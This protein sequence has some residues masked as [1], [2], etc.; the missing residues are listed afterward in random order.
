MSRILPSEHLQDRRRPFE[1][2]TAGEYLFMIT[3]DLSGDGS[4]DFLILIQRFK[5][6]LLPLAS[7][8]GLT[9]G[10]HLQLLTTMTLCT[11]Y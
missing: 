8:A 6:L 9:P 1:F 2:R 7:G 3:I 5:E 11:V 10:R 4:S